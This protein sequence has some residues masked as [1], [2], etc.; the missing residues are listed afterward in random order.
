MAPKFIPKQIIDTVSGYGKLLKSK[1][2]MYDKLILFGSY[3]TN[4][5]HPSSDIDVGV[6]S[7]KIND[8]HKMQVELM[9]YTWGYDTRIEPHPILLSD[10]MKNANPFINEVRLNGVEVA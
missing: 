5:Y 7:E 8:E 2:V 6:V 3:S 1:G 9:K 4:T 10:Y